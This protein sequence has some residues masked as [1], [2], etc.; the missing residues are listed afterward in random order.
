MDPL[1][2][3]RRHRPR[4]D[5]YLAHAVGDQPEVAARV[6]LVGPL[7]GN[8]LGQPDARTGNVDAALVRLRAGQ[9]DGS[10]LGVGKTTRGIAS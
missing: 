3:E 8:H 4:P 6:L 10:N 7:A 5:Q 9:P 2:R 1:A